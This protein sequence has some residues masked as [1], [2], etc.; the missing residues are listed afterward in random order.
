MVMDEKKSLF[1]VLCVINRAKHHI[2]EKEMGQKIEDLGYKLGREKGSNKQPLI[3]QFERKLEPDG[4]GRT[5]HRDPPLDYV[6]VCAKLFELS[7][8]EKYDLFIAALQSSEKLIFDRNAIDGEIEEEI[9]SI[10]LS[11]IL[12]GK[13]LGNIVKKHQENKQKSLLYVYPENTNDREYYFAWDNLSKASQ[14]LIE[15]VRKNY[16][17]YNLNDA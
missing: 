5:Q 10:I 15:V 7:P 13:K 12:S 3:S 16:F 4:P 11:L 14:R 1:G 8:P 6:E 17:D 9:I 2:K